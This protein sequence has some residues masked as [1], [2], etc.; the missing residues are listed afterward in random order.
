VSVGV[1]RNAVEVSSPMVYQYVPENSLEEGRT[2]LADWFATR[3][4]M[5]AHLHAAGI[6]L[7]SDDAYSLHNTINALHSDYIFRPNSKTAGNL[8]SADTFDVDLLNRAARQ[9]KILNPKIRPASTPRGDR[10]VVFLSPEQV[11]DL[12]SSDS[13]WFA[14][15]QNALKGGRIDDN[16]LLNN[17]L[18]EWSG[19]LFF[20][21]ELVPPGLNS[22]GTKI[23]DKTRRA[24]I[25]GAQ[26]LFLAHGRSETPPG[27]APSKYRW[28]RESEDFGHV[29]Q[30]AATT[31]AG[32]ARPRYQKPGEASARENGVLVI[33]TYADHGLTGSDVYNKWTAISG[34]TLES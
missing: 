2:A 24:W 19:F 6:S 33:E 10:Y 15:M 4:C 11:H 9:L 18:G 16:P 29:K 17:A 34:V 20:E 13:L 3:Y 27:F 7:V 26:S 12:R 5:S 30:I 31:I 21:S 28:D 32:M 22:D 1:L 8:T 14:T 25:G 23:K